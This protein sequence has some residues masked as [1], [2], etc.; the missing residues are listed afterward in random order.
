[1]EKVIEKKLGSYD[2]IKGKGQVKSSSER[3]LSDDHAE[4][5]SAASSLTS[6]TCNPSILR[7]NH[8]PIC[9]LPLLPEFTITAQSNSGMWTHSNLSKK[10]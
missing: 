9:I 2:L 10:S 6:R 5:E 3:T 1:M 7:L 4:V 8:E